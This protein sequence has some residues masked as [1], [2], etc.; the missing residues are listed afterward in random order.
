MKPKRTSREKFLFFIVLVFV[1]V[2]LCDFQWKRRVQ[3][4]Q[5]TNDSNT[6]TSLLN[7]DES[8]QHSEQS[9]TV[10]KPILKSPSGSF[11]WAESNI[12]D[13]P[14]RI[15]WT[16][17]IEIVSS[18]IS[19]PVEDTDCAL[20]SALHRT[21]LESISDERDARLH[22][23]LLDPFAI[24]SKQNPSAVEESM[25]TLAKELRSERNY[26]T[27]KGS[28]FVLVCLT[29]FCQPWAEKFV[30]VLAN[31]QGT[32]AI[33]VGVDVK[34]MPLGWPCPLRVIDVYANGL[35]DVSSLWK[36]ILRRASFMT[37]KQNRWICSDK[38]HPPEH[39]GRHLPSM[40]YGGVFMERSQQGKI[41]IF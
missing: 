39:F 36:K 10:A 30:E 32:R 19:C 27:Y 12:K 26:I 38:K 2:T 17:Q 7:P 11:F 1:L 3:L 29:S 9:W 4:D 21:V 41:D 34:G 15:R 8:L 35:E 14:Y 20:F 25:Q 16:S 28:D 6:D 24:E 31:D 40:P 18:R 22:V 5:N 13:A 33:Y 23:V 37:E